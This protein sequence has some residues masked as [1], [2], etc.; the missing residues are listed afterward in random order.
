MNTYL[1]RIFDIEFDYDKESVKQKF[2]N[3]L[4]KNKLY[5]HAI[6]FIDIMANINT[7][8]AKEIESKVQEL[9]NLIGIK[10]SLTSTDSVEYFIDNLKY[11]ENAGLYPYN[12]EKYLASEDRFEYLLML[13]DEDLEKNFFPNIFSNRKEYIEDIIV[14]SYKF[15]CDRSVE[16]FLL[17][18]KVYNVGKNLKSYSELDEDQMKIADVCIQNCI[19]KFKNN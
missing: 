5:T 8:D 17:H 13:S 18:K 12:K 16:K 4:S 15:H 6:K 3:V 10:V 9:M 7:Q 2:L 11:Y 1:K 19:Q 14:N